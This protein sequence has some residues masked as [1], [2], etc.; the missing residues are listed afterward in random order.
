MFVVSIHPSVG[1]NHQTVSPSN[2]T[3][4]WNPT[5][6]TTFPFHVTH[7]LTPAHTPLLRSFRPSVK[8]QPITETDL[9]QR[10]GCND[11]A[12]SV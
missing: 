7:P 5:L 9:E 2:T 3:R 6:T 11:P 1:D 10:S 12:I 8:N 4:T